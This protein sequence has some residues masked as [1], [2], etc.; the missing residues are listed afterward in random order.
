M[1]LIFSSTS[2]SIAA[3][4][5]CNAAVALDVDFDGTVA[6]VCSLSLN[7]NGTLA[8]SGDG[9]E[10]GSEVSGGSAAG[11]LVLSIGANSVDVDA[12]NR[13]T[14]DPSGYNAASEVI[15]VKYSGA[16]GLSAVSQDYT[17]SNTSFAVSNIALSLLTLHNRIVNTN[18]FAAGNY[19]TRTVVTCS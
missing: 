8:L 18:G 16:G 10:L 5:V 6:T 9:T 19:T 3:F 15:E 11:V 2:V 13:I 7:S 17:S 4:L 12:P 1:R 14:A